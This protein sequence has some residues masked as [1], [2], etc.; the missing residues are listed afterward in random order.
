MSTEGWSLAVAAS[1]ERS[2]NRLPPKIATATVEFMLGPLVEAPRRVGHPLRRELSGLWSARRGAYRIVYELNE[3][4]WLINV[5]RIDH[6]ADV[7]RP[8]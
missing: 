3:A 4:E 7:Y 5:V 1:A 6:R 8:R 2:L